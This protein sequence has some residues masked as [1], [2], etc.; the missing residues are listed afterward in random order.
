[1]LLLKDM[2]NKLVNES[3]LV[4][5]VANRIR[6][7]RK[8]QKL[9]QEALSLKA[10]LDP[11]YINKLENFRFS[12]KLETLDRIL[13]VL[14]LTYSDFFQFDINISDNEVQKLLLAISKLPEEVRESKIDAII[15]LL[16]SYT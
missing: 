12:C 14:G 16:N 13:N 11:K 7:L 4:Y 5:F 15:V 3:S 10:G 2:K 1:M 8:S 6:I 9:S